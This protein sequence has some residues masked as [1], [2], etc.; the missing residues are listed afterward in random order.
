MVFLEIAPILL[1]EDNHG[2]IC[3]TQHGHFKGRIKYLD[4]R[5]KFIKDCI[6]TV[7][8]K[9]VTITSENMIADIDTAARPAPAFKITSA[10]S[11]RHAGSPRHTE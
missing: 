8:L 7:V 1:F 4:L 3:L 6:D 11:S 5:W 2:A 10:D 9:L